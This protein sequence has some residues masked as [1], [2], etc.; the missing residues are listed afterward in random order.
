MIDLG[1]EGLDPFLV[2]ATL[3][4]ALL[5]AAGLLRVHAGPTVFDRLVAV[6]L[7]SVN[8]VALI[9]LIG[10]LLDRPALFLDIAL[11]FALLVFLLPLTLGRYFERSGGRTDR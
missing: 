10:F 5:I 2:V 11:G 3:V 7:V 9:A 4:I 1:L 6:S 8:G